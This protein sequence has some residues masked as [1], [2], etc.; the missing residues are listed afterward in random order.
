MKPKVIIITLLVIGGL[1][2]IT[3]GWQPTVAALRQIVYPTNRFDGGLVGYWSFNGSDVSGTTA[4]DRSG[5][6]L[7]GTIAGAPK[8]RGGVVGQALDFDGADNTVSVAHNALLSP[9]SVSVEF[10]ML[11]NREVNFQGPVMKTSSGTWNDGYG[12]YNRS[13]NSKFTWW[14]DDYDASASPGGYVTIDMPSLG[15]WHHVVGTYDGATVTLYIDGAVSGT[16]FSYATGITYVDSTLSIGL[17]PSGSYWDGAIDEV[18]V[19]NRAMSAT[20]VAEHYKTTART[21]G[22]KQ[23]ISQNN[24][25]DGGLVGFWPFNGADI[26]GVTASDRSGQGNNGTL[27]SGPTTATGVV[28]Q[29][30]KFDGVNDYITIA[31]PGADDFGTGPMSVSAWYKTGSLG[32]MTPIDNK[33]A[34]TNL[35][36]FNLYVNT[37]TNTMR[38]RIAN[39]AAQAETVGTK[40]INDNQWHHSVGV[41]DGDTITLYTDGAQDGTPTTGV[42]AWDITSANTIQIAAYQSP[43][44]FWNGP[45]DEIRL[46]NRVL[47]ATEVAEIYRAG[48]PEQRSKQNISQNNRFDGGLVGFWPFNGPDVSGTVATD[49]GSG[50]NNGTLT[51][52]PTVASGVVGQALKFDGINDYVDVVTPPTLTAFSIS[53]WVR[54]SGTGVHPVVNFG[55]AGGVPLVSLYWDTTRHIIYMGGSNYRYFNAD[56]NLADNNWHHVVFTIPGTADADITTSA[57]Y[58]DGVLQSTNATVSTGAQTAKSIL[59]I[60]R[61]AQVAAYFDGLLDEVRAYNRALSATEVAEIYRAGKRE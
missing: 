1:L 43:G 4:T 50:G 26:S 37:N 10:W 33:Q 41:R 16:P 44:G 45:L 35:A 47:S 5:G 18:R 36:G 48:A 61:T 20:E 21:E 31:N 39:G 14:V 40:A 51:G 12:F 6:G 13:T 30:L 56:T 17:P 29:A 22:D 25:Y 42:S 28:G 7:N 52:G 34:G 46:Y 27:T 53:G 60:G 15:Q 3:L 23:S 38:F 9:A 59:W 49:R 8:R 54:I 19:Y 2:I 11:A 55:A 32:Y 24:R 57:I 58:V